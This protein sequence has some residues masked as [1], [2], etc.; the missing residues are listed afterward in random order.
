MQ[1]LKRQ[2]FKCVTCGHEWEGFA[3]SFCPHDGGK[4]MYK[5]KKGEWLAPTREEPAFKL[6]GQTAPQR[7]D[8]E[9]DE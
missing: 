3:G 1:R 8:E 9:E 4:P 2:P 7:L 5:T 6:Y